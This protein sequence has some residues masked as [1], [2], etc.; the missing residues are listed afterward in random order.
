LIKDSGNGF[1]EGLNT[2]DNT[3]SLGIYLIRTLVEQIDGGVQFSN[4]QGAR[5]ALN[6]VH[7]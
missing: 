6:F 4:D 1:P 5:I 3:G 2:L 7:N